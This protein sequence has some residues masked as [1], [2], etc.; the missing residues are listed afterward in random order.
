MNRLARWLGSPAA[1]LVAITAVGSGQ[2]WR[3]S[4]D[5]W[6]WTDRAVYLGTLWL[7]LILQSAQNRDTAAMQAKLD[8]IIREL[9]GTNRAV[10][11]ENKSIKDIEEVKRNA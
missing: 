7:A 6:L 2:L 9:P 8:D 10:G 1:L 3:W 5:W 4:E 11:L